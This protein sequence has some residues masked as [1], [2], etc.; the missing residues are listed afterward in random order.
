MKVLTMV[1]S[2]LFL[3]GCVQ[4]PTRNTQTVDDRPGI[5]F[6]IDTAAAEQYEL[7]VDGVSYGRVGQYLAGENVLKLVDGSHSIELVSDGTVV[8]QDKVYLGAGV[9]RVIKVGSNE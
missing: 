7:K 5:A 3:I 8:Y 2:V 1:L 4:G 6:N 9:N